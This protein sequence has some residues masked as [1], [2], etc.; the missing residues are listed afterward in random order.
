MNDLLIKQNYSRFK[1]TPAITSLLVTFSPVCFFGR[2][3]EGWSCSCQAGYRLGWVL[4]V[5]M[6]SVIGGHGEEKLEYL[7]CTAGHVL[8][9]FLFDMTWHSH[10]NTFPY[11]P[12]SELAEILPLAPS[13]ESRQRRML[14]EYIFN[15]LIIFFLSNDLSISY[16]KEYKHV[17]TCDTCDN[18]VMKSWLINS[19]FLKFCAFA[20]FRNPNLLCC[21]FFNFK[22]EEGQIYLYVNINFWKLWLEWT[23]YKSIL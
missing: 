5:W 2:E 12:P 3:R 22:I 1:R 18:Y 14:G 9:F 11:A 21:F 4:C 23:F 6:S 16:L 20:S 15:E 13:S 10:A 7:C 8:Y 17:I 19:I